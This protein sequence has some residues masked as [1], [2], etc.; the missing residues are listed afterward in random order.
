MYLFTMFT[1]LKN[2]NGWRLVSKCLERTSMSKT[3]QL[4]KESLEHTEA[5]RCRKNSYE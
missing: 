2:V 1:Y 5:T 3:K 4:L